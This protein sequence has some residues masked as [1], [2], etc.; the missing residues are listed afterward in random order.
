MTVRDDLQNVWLPGN[1]F[2]SKYPDCKVVVLPYYIG[3]GICQ[4]DQYY[5]LL[6]TEAC[7]FDG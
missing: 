4:N 1:S 7:G 2:P 5:L 3:N 6:N